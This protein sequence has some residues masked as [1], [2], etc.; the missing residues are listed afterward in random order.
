MQSGICKSCRQAS[1]LMHHCCFVG[2]ACSVIPSVSFNHVA[3]QL[4]HVLL[5]FGGVCFVQELTAVKDEEEKEL[6]RLR[7]KELFLKYQIENLV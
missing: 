7:Q 6:E 5:Q 3:M 2:Q 1:V 4:G